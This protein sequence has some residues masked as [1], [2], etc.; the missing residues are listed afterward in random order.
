MQKNIARIQVILSSVV[1]WLVFA[2]FVLVA[3]ADEFPGEYTSY[4]VKAAAVIGS[5][6]L[7]IRKVSPAI[8]G[9]EGILPPD[10]DKSRE[11]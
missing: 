6:V 9:T 7:I 11:V 3:L 4:A 2:Q 8:P 10:F 1:T 5:V